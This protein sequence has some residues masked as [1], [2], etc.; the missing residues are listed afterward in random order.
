MKK[1][2]AGLCAGSIALSLTFANVASTLAAPV[3]SPQAP[4]GLTHFEQVQYNQE[5]RKRGNGQGRQMYRGNRSGQFERRGN[6][7]YYNGHRGYNRGRA[8]YRQYNG[9]W[10]PAAAF[11]TG[12]IIGGALGSAPSAY[13]GGGSNHV[14]WCYDRWRSYR[15]S[16]NSYQPYNGPRKQCMSPYS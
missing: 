2:F 10:F 3:I 12:A 13:R 16:D 5:W 6:R 1:I 8:G 9:F 4:A 7:A 11:I 15:A 14:Q